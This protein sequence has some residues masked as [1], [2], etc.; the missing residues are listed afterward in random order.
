MAQ[1]VV[2]ADDLPDDPLAAAAAFHAGIVP[3]VRAAT[4]D[5][6]ITLAA[7]D[8]T[9]EGWRLAA[10]QSLARAAAPAARVNAIAGGDAAAQAAALAFLAA[11]PGVTGQVL[12]LAGNSA[13]SA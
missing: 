10:V 11:A 1:Q 6:V 2:R 9:H 13:Q 8:H 12:V 7:A 3:Q 4:G 5:V